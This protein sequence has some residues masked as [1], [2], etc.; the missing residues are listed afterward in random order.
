MWLA[1]ALCACV[2]GTLLFAVIVIDRAL[3]SVDR[4]V[5][6]I[7]M[8]LKSGRAINNRVS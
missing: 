6:R 1:Y 2:A 5:T 8:A 7:E 4:R 3:A